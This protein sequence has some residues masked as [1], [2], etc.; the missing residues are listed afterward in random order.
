VTSLDQNAPL[1]ADR[2]A[3][4]RDLNVDSCSADAPYNPDVWALEAA[5]IDLLAEVD[6]LNKA[7]ALLGSQLQGGAEAHKHL[8]QVIVDL[9]DTMREAVTSWLDSGDPSAAMAIVVDKVCEAPET[10][11]GFDGLR[12]AVEDGRHVVRMLLLDPDCRD[13]KCSSCVGGPCEHECHQVDAG[14]D[15]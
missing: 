1:C 2:L 10:S 11:K 6:R 4:I 12:M 13:E 15:T 5:R 9:V 3:E 14:G 8:G 7:V